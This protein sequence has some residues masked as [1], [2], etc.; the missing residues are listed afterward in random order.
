MASGCPV[1]AS[2]ASSI[3]EICG[4][5]A[6]YCDPF[7]VDD[8]ADKVKLTLGLKQDER[9]RFVAN[10]RAHARRFGWEQCA[11]DTWNVLQHADG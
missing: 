10:A 6:I 5:A 3:P 4:E 1:V 9:L 2:R 11:R 8:I 7:S